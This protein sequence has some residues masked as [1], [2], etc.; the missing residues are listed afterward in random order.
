MVG[1]DFAANRPRLHEGEYVTLVVSDTGAG[2]DDRTMERIFEPFFTT[3]EVGQGS[4]LGLSVVHGIVVR[5]DG[6]IIVSST[7]GGGSSFRVFLPLAGRW[8]TERQQETGI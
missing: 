3:Q 4:G 6:D 8:A 2:M 7:P 5:H 1:A